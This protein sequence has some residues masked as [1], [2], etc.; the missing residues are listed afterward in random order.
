M[1]AGRRSVA[2]MHMEVEGE[3]L[4]C[5]H[6]GLDGSTIS[7]G[8]DNT[9]AGLA[10]EHSLSPKSSESSLSD[11]SG[12]SKSLSFETSWPPSRDARSEVG[13]IGHDAGA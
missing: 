8:M 12:L 10:P 4:F 3:R 11:S 9:G 1:G 5:S 2:V 7:A 6:S 13:M